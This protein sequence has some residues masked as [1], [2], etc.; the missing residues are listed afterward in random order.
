MIELHTTAKPAGLRLGD[1]AAILKRV[2]ELL[3]GVSEAAE[4]KRLRDP[5]LALDDRLQAALAYLYDHEAFQ[6]SA[7]ISAR[8]IVTA[9]S[10]ERARQNVPE[11]K[12][13]ANDLTKLITPHRPKWVRSGRG[14]L[15]GYHLAVDG[16]RFV[17]AALQRIDRK[18]IP[19]R[20]P[21]D[22]TKE[23]RV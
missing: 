6:P 20:W 18:L 21:G 5:F 2:D 10:S 9:L 16:R 7:A 19:R 8:S 22:G 13:R 3:G 17:L 11:M 14:R 12:L 1:E 23:S 15:G 4:R